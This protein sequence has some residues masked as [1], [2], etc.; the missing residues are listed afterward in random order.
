M[1][2]PTIFSV[3]NRLLFIIA[4]SIGFII[5]ELAVGFST[6]SLAVVG[7][8]IHYIGDVLSFVVAYLAE[9]Y[10]D[11]TDEDAEKKP[12]DGA[13]AAD[14]VATEEEK[15]VRSGSDKKHRLLYRH[16]AAFFNSVFLL[17]LGLAIFLQG[18]ERFV[19]PERIKNPWIVM[20]MG[21]IGVFLNIVSVLI[22]GG[23]GHAHHGHANHGHS[24]DHGHAPS[25]SHSH[26]NHHHDDGHSHSHPPST[27]TAATLTPDVEAHAHGHPHNHAGV[28]LSVK[29][30]LLHVIGD[31][32]NNIAVIITGVI[33]W[34]APPHD[35]N[36]D[37]C[38]IG[39]MPAKYYAD[40]ACT[41]AI[42]LMIMAGS[43]RMSL[44][45]GRAL[46]DK[47]S[48]GAGAAA[49]ECSSAVLSSDTEAEGTKSQGLAGFHQR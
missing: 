11:K 49:D 6:Q 9:V 1:K 13:A 12:A 10:S 2:T 26:D 30:V 47:R 32:L 48:A 38:S 31:I 39:R 44:T 41:A 4:T 40:P 3:K 23:H 35:E 33:V 18:L 21:C 37:E 43:V 42:A 7:D 45:S 17:G 15:Q 8:A 14:N 46:V 34:K 5:A 27:K 36:L 16:L 19:N 29:A 25:H 22:L 28:A 24:H 20:M